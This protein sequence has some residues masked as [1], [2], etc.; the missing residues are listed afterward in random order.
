MHRLGS[1]VRY[2]AWLEFRVAIICRVGWPMASHEPM[3]GILLNIPQHTEWPHGSISTKPET[4]SELKLR[5]NS[6]TLTDPEENEDGH[7]VSPKELE[8]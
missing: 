7:P 4:L 1:S 2:L 6:R 3:S 8:W 5:R